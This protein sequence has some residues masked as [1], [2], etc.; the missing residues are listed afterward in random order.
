MLLISV[1]Q[2]AFIYFG[3]DTFRATPLVISD[4]LYVILISFSIVVFDFIR[5]LLYKR[6]KI[7]KERKRVKKQVI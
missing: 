6:R 4:L 3:G 5:K 1:M 2:M 7:R